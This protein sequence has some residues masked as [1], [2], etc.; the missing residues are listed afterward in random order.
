ME[1]IAEV[2]TGN[3]GEQ[4]PVVMFPVCIQEYITSEFYN[5]NLLPG[6]Q[7]VY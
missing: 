7:E 5:T 2:I 3:Q 4:N 1:K 6:N